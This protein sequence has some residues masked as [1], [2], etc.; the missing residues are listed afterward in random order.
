MAS[1]LFQV[2]FHPKSIYHYCRCLA[3][4]ANILSRIGTQEKDRRIYKG[5]LQPFVSLI[6]PCPSTSS[7]SS[8]LKIF[9][10]S[11]FILS[12]RL[13]ERI[14]VLFRRYYIFLTGGNPFLRSIVIIYCTIFHVSP[15]EFALDPFPREY[16]A[17]SPQTLF[18][19]QRLSSHSPLHHASITIL[20]FRPEAT[21]II[22][23]YRFY[24]GPF[25]RPTLP[26]PH[27]WIS[28]EK[29]PEAT[30]SIFHY[31]E[32]DQLGIHLLRIFVSCCRC[33][34]ASKTM[35]RN[36]VQLCPN[37]LVVAYSYQ[38]RETGLTS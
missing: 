28:Y 26:Q 17:T 2:L 29:L 34:S 11:R 24:S 20:S 8:S 3:L 19:Q 14:H 36:G 22:L 27:P 32:S 38:N 18:I 23:F 31:A 10:N 16:H 9:K 1:N 15:Q 35:Q 33:V 4:R 6:R 37:F 12:Q 21:V 5:L 7:P 13:T 30:T 25:L